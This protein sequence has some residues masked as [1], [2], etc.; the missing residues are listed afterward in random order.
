MIA[1]SLWEAR[2]RGGRRTPI[3][4][5]WS[6]TV[7]RRPR[8]ETVQSWHMSARAFRSARPGRRRE[9]SP[10]AALAGFLIGTTGMFAVM[11]S[12]QAILPELARHFDRSEARAGLTVSVVVL[13]IAVGGWIWGPLSDRIGRRRS[14]VLASSLVV[15]PTV[16]AALAPTFETLL[17]ARTLQGLCMP[18]LMIGR[19]PVR[20]GAVRRAHR[21]PG[22]GVLRLRR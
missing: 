20:D 7:P 6:R 18:G 19:H 21:R 11:Y 8:R 10:R 1:V 22:D 3:A 4:R 12:T 16:G 9:R 15:L 5:A 14:L 2:L 13:T 17:A